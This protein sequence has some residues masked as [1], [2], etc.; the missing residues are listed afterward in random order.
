MSLNVK[1]LR[2][3]LEAVKP[4]A[5]EFSTH[6]YKTLF[7]IAPAAK[8]LFAKT[9]FNKQKKH[10]IGAIVQ[11]VN[12]VDQPEK[13]VPYLKEMGARHVDYGTV[14]EHYPIVGKALIETFKYFF[15]EKWT[16]QLESTWLAAFQ[17]I[18][19][20]ML[21]GAAEMKHSS[22]VSIEHEDKH[23]VDSWLKDWSEKALKLAIKRA[24]TDPKIK[25]ELQKQAAEILSD[26]L[27]EEAGKVMTDLKKAS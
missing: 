24:S 19:D 25:A 26:F 4:I 21:A 10:L 23:S 18:T 3:S 9:D 22:V 15:E 27:K 5:D 7:E 11:I 13:L 14:A 16:P 8:E 12:T 17:V 20:T 1:L 2:S 6:F